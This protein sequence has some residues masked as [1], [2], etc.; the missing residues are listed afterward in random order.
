MA[1]L[2]KE[3]DFYRR[4]CDENG[5]RI[6]ELLNEQTRVRRE[7]RRKSVLARLIR[8][9]FPLASADAST[10]LSMD[11]IARKFL[12]IVIDSVRVDGG[13]IVQRRPKEDRFVVL[14][15]LGLIERVAEADVPGDRIQPFAFASSK[16]SYDPFL[17]V[18][19]GLSGVPYFLWAFDETTGF[20]LLL[21]NKNEDRHLYLPFEDKDREIV[22]GA[23]HIF[24]RIHQYKTAEKTLRESE[25]SEAQL[26]TI[27]HSIPAGVLLIDASTNLIIY[28]N[29]IAATLTGQSVEELVGRDCRNFLCPATD[30]RYPVE[31]HGL[32]GENT[33]DAVFKADGTKIPVIK[34]AV[35]LIINGRKVF[36]ESFV[37]IRERKRMEEEL[38]QAKEG[39]E[40]ANR[41]KSQFLANM[42]HEIRTPP[43]RYH[44]YGGS[45][46]ENRAGAQSAGIRR[47]GKAQRRNLAPPYL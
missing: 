11:E 37:D 36:L 34:S 22:E 40:S 33:E 20:A 16:T 29:R 31:D 43:E 14:C 35:P 13:M 23:L 30:S 28:A 18:L 26:K 12:Q 5:A 27:L 42:S 8:E 46:P 25:A 19:Q 41:A 47:K 6:I 44:R 10:E 9:S 7:A 4:Q 24:T 2:E 32:T 39:A 38:K 17:S 21:G 15:T 45:S 1:D 3:L